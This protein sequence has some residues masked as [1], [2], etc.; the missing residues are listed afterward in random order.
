MMSYE[1]VKRFSEIAIEKSIDAWYTDDIADLIPQGTICECG[2]TEFIKEFDILDVWSDSGVSHY[3]VLEKWSALQWPAELYLEG[4]DQH[5]GW[6]QSSLWTSV[7]LKGRAPFNAVLTHGFVLDEKGKA[8][9]KSVGNVIHPEKLIKQFGADILR[10]WVSSEDYRNDVKIGMDMMKQ[11]ADSYRKIRNTFKFMIGNL[12]GFT[13]KNAVPYDQ[14]SDI[15]KWILHKLFS[16]SEQVIE[17]YEK[18]EF[19]L[20]YKK[21]LNFCAIELSSIYFDISKD[22]LYVEETNGIKRRAVQTVLSETSETLLRLIAPVL[23]FT[24]EEI[25]QFKGKD[26]SVHMEQY[27]ILDKKYNNSEIEKKMEAMVNIKKDVLK[28]LE[29]QRAEKIIGSSLEAEI[30]LFVKNEQVRNWIKKMKDPHYFFQVAAVDIL[31]ARTDGLKDYDN[32]AITSAKT[33]GTKCVRCWNYTSNAGTDK[34][35]PDLCPRC[36]KIVVSA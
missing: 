9:S 7:A 17:S 21:I 24:A 31:D 8:M 22:I 26:D 12:P 16:L 23:S 18:F 15:D 5:R 30:S 10:L 11:V 28:A 36:T 3:A 32:S 1:S 4:S 35:H 20:V 34:E 13:N 2:S 14:L 33:S 6:F 29:L 19:H 27:Y 25:W